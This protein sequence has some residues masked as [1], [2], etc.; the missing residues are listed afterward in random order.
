MLFRSYPQI[1]HIILC[2][3]QTF[4]RFG[5][6]SPVLNRREDAKF[7]FRKTKENWWWRYISTKFWKWLSHVPRFLCLIFIIKTC[8]MRHQKSRDELAIPDA[9]CH[10]RWCRDIRRNIRNQ[11]YEPYLSRPH[12]WRRALIRWFSL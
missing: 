3:R 1:R 11:H 6:A 2:E 4:E 12:H 9:N 8:S 7:C 5:K 10:G